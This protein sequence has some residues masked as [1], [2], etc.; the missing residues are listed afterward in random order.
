MWYVEIQWFDPSEPPSEWSR[1]PRKYKT[2]EAA[3]RAAINLESKNMANGA[4]CNCRSV[5]VK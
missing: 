2:K 3:D 4:D 1:L 5:E